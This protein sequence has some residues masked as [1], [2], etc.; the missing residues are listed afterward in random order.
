MSRKM[1]EVIIYEDEDH[2]LTVRFVPITQD[3]KTSFHGTLEVKI[4]EDLYLWHS[5]SVPAWY[6]YESGE[7]TILFSQEAYRHLSWV[8]SLLRREFK[9]SESLIYDGREITSEEEYMNIPDLEEVLTYMVV[10]T[11][12]PRKEKKEVPL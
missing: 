7:L 2:M 9:T 11:R 4:L 12:E 6:D 1:S 8:F 5:A 3:G 10:K